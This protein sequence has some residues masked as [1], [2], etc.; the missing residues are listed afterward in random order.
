MD[1]KHISSSR[2]H[3]LRRRAQAMEFSTI[4]SWPSKAGDSCMGALVPVQTCPG[5]RP[6]PL[7]HPPSC[8]LGTKLHS[9][10]SDCVTWQALLQSLTSARISVECRAVVDFASV[11]SLSKASSSWPEDLP[12]YYYVGLLPFR[13]TIAWLTSVPNALLKIHNPLA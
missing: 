4:T 6:P 12:S 3:L 10:I 1:S 13:I 9:F 2:T 7:H 8:T 11:S 5:S